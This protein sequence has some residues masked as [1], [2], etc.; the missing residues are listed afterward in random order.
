LAAL[1]RGVWLLS[2]ADNNAAPLPPPLLPP[3]PPPSFLG[4]TPLMPAGG[5][6]QPVSRL[7][8]LLCPVLIPHLLH[9]LQRKLCRTGV[10]G[11]VG[12]TPAPAVTVI[13]LATVVVIDPAASNS[14]VDAVL[15]TAVMLQLPPRQ[16]REA[17][18][19]TPWLMP[20]QQLP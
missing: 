12:A 6:V 11:G 15:T 3:L 4:A 18:P 1:D 19:P 9:S 13:L 20:F 10:K 5:R 17:L 16:R 14:V 2:K 7:W 8:R